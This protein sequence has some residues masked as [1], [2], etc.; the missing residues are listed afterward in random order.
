MNLTFAAVLAAALFV[1]AAKTGWVS[2][3]NADT[4]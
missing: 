3:I 1:Q 4:F 2:A